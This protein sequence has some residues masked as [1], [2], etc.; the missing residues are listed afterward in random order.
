MGAGNSRRWN[1]KGQTRV[2]TA[3]LVSSV[4]LSP[5]HRQQQHTNEHF[6][7][8]CTCTGLDRTA[9]GVVSRDTTPVCFLVYVYGTRLSRVVCLSVNE[10]LSRSLPLLLQYKF[11]PPTGD[12]PCYQRGCTPEYLLQSCHVMACHVIATRWLDAVTLAY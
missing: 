12:D 11:F 5:D 7:H 2:R 4:A 10:P 6:G 3:Q 1:Y 9:V 8:T